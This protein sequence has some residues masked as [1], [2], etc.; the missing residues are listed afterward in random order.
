MQFNDARTTAIEQIN[1][2]YQQRQPPFDAIEFPEERLLTE[3]GIT[4]TENKLR[5]ISAFC[6]FDYNRTTSQL[7]DNLIKLYETKPTWFIP[8]ALPDEDVVTELFSEIGFRYP[9]RDAHGWITNN[10]ILIEKYDSRWRNLLEFVEYNAYRLVEQLSADDFL[11]LKG[12][13]IAPMYARIIDN[14]AKPLKN[15]WNLEMPVDT[16]I[17]RLS[18]E[19]MPTEN[20][21]DNDIR[22]FWRYVANNNDIERHVI[23]GALWQIG[24]NWD[25]WGGKYWQNVTN[26]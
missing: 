2:D 20:P 23:D 18:T 16:H 22:K 11:Y 1:K 24:N 5:I 26:S 10:Q 9:T 25:E 12:D 4:G 14:H 7:V 13:K 8:E 6:T 21:S 17:R 19:L 15:L 3:T